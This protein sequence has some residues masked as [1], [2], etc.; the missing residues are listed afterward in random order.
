MYWGM[1]VY[2]KSAD[3]IEQSV[4][5]LEGGNG[6][7]LVS[8]LFPPFKDFTHDGG[9]QKNVFATSTLV[10]SSANP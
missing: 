2:R 4:I 8:T 5:C 9:R 6:A 3:K 7:S 10:A 1:R